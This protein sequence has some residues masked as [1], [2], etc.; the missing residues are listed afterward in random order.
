MLIVNEGVL[1]LLSQ[2]PGNIIVC[3]NLPL[4]LIEGLQ[5]QI[6]TTEGTIS[7]LN[8]E[9][10]QR[11]FMHFEI[12]PLNSVYI[13]HDEKACKVGEDF[14]PTINWSNDVHPLESLVTELPK[15]LI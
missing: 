1:K 13:E 8:P 15:L 5:F 6:F 14:I 4:N 7:K 2:F 3:T 11:L 9:Y 10:F 12:D